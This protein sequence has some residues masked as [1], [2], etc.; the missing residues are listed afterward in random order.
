V[1]EA[2]RLTELAKTRPGRLLVSASVLEKIDDDAELAHWQLDGETL[3]RGRNEPTALA[4][5]R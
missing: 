4:V 1:N 3:L 2:A 5:T